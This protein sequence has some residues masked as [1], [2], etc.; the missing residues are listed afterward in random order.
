MTGIWDVSNESIKAHDWDGLWK[1]SLLTSLLQPVGLVLLRLLPK[2]T[3]EQE[4]MQK[5]D[6]RNFWG[7]L[8]FAGFLIGALLWTISEA[9]I[10][11][12]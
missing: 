10:M 1:L 4:K 12:G 7:G 2:N 9:I 8:C 5:S 11:L 3:E 6:Q